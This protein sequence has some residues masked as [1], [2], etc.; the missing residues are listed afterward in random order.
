MISYFIKIFP[1]LIVLLVQKNKT[2]KTAMSTVEQ[3]SY[4]FR[5]SGINTIVTMALSPKFLLTSSYT[6]SSSLSPVDILQP[7][8][9]NLNNFFIWGCTTHI[10]K[11]L[12]HHKSY[13]TCYICVYS[14]FTLFNTLK[15][16]LNQ[17]IHLYQ[18]SLSFPCLLFNRIFLLFL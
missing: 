1:L 10:I 13:T 16:L 2:N 14:V 9:T 6:P 5:L 4:Q 15:V 12:L 3:K 17:G 7:S 8:N 11:L 18:A